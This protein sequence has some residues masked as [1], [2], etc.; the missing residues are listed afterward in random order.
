MAVDVRRRVLAPFG[1]RVLPP[2]TLER[3]E[4]DHLTDAL[5][6]TRSIDD[7]RNHG[8]SRK[9][10]EDFA[11]KPRGSQPSLDDGYD[12][13]RIR[14]HKPFSISFSRAGVSQTEFPSLV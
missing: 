14:G 12:P 10:L 8:L 9:W 2:S 6:P 1:V 11:G 7:P 13:V 5:R 3:L 4:T